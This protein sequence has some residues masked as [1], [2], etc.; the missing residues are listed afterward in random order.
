MQA[1]KRF[2]AEGHLIDSGILTKLLN[3]IIEEGADYEIAELKVG[4]TELLPSSLELDVM[5]ATEERL[6]DLEKKL[7]RLG[8]Y[9]KAAPEAVFKPAEKKACVP[10]DFYSTTNHRTEVFFG[11]GWHPVGRQRMDGVIVKAPSGLVCKKLREVEPADPV[12]CGS[13]SVRVF[14]PELDRQGSSFGFMENPVSSERSVKLLVR[15]LAEE[16]RGITGRQG[17]I[18]AVVGP[19]VVHTGGIPA[20]S[21]LIRGGFINGVLAGNALAVHDIETAYFNTSLGVDKDSG[22]PTRE[23]HRNHMR[24]INRVNRFGSIRQAVEAGDLTTGIMYEIVRKGIPFCLAGSIRDDGPL[25]ETATDMIEAQRRYAEICE[26][27]E[28]ILMLSSMLHSIG[29]G[30]MIPSWIK[31]VCV[32]INPAVV[33][34]LSDRGTSQAVGVVSDVGL[35]INALAEQLGCLAKGPSRPGE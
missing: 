9:G 35:F 6:S 34:K 16:I 29:T 28:M 10:D 8:C 18:V 25:P 11:G 15:D 14:P 12:L 21:G 4:K 27:A 23:G 1:R 26:G 7:V 2:T 19:V 13:E 32:D 22:R 20:L 17:K 33:T 24:A 5:A 3:L 31:T 30:N